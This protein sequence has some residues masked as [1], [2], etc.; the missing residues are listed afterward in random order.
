VPGAMNLHSQVD[1][2][3]Q[4]VL[5]WTTGQLQS[6]SNINGPYTD[7]SGATS[8]YTVPPSNAQQYFRIRAQV[9]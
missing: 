8:P 2:S 6:A 7:V 4:I 1:G 3:G 5:T 9:Q